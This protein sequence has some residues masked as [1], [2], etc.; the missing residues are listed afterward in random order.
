M[1]RTGGGRGIRFLGAGMLGHPRAVLAR[2]SLA[3]FRR[4]TYNL[5]GTIAQARRYRSCRTLKDEKLARRIKSVDVKI[6]NPPR[7]GK[8]CLVLDIDYTL[9]DLVSSPPQRVGIKQQEVG[10]HPG[11]LGAIL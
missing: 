6:L 1:L 4:L 8:K 11:V 5:Y 3:Q 9:F 7:P 10:R 2:T